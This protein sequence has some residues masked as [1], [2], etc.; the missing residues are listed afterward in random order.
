ME[1]F[2]NTS[3]FVLHDNFSF[4]VLIRNN[5][6]TISGTISYNDRTQ[7]QRRIHSKT[8]PLSVYSPPQQ[9]Q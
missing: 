9:G 6:Q 3:K 5:F 4:H 2:N 1:L 7:F 8:L